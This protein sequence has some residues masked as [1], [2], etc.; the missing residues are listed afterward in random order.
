ML[1]LLEKVSVSPAKKPPTVTAAPASSKLS[2]SLA[3]SLERRTTGVLFNEA[4]LLTLSVKVGLLVGVI[5]SVGCWS[6]QSS[7]GSAPLVN[8]RNCV[9][10]PP[11]RLPFHRSMLPIESVETYQVPVVGSIAM[12]LRVT[13]GLELEVSCQIL[14]KLPV[15]LPVR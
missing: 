10:A 9:G 4:G 1:L 6:T 13:D 5:D 14:E 8:V 11:L 15:G 3:V 2:G 12:A 7:S